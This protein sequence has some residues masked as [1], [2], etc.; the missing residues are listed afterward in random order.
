MERENL[1]ELV[2]SEVHEQNN[3]KYIS[4]DMFSKY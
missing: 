3:I 4:Y 1:E 2:K